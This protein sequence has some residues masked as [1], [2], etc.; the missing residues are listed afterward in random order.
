MRNP[1]SL[2]R[3]SLV[4]GV[5]SLPLLMA[6]A[7]GAHAAGMPQLDFRNPL[8][9]GQV[10]WGAGIFLFF[11][12]ALRSWALPK[13]DTVLASR[14]Q[15][16]NGDLDQAHAAKVDAD[17]AVRELNETKK[18]A[19]AEAQAHLD[20]V[21][22]EERKQTA[23]RLAELGSKLEVE[24]ASAEK[25]VAEERSRALESLKPIASDVAEALVQKLTGTKPDRV[26]IEA[27]VAKVAAEKSTISAIA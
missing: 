15:R 4:A 10:I 21:L 18:A 8:L 23:S 20:A 27:A 19:A 2:I 25:A 9:T 5:S 17:N 11:Y 24:I 22:D 7:P 12:L 14:S 1:V 6:A 26:R 13:V 16:I 3:H